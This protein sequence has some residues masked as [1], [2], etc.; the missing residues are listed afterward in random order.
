MFGGI[1]R[2]AVPVIAGNLL[3]ELY[4][5]VDTLIVGRTLG[6][7]KLAA[8][9][10]TASLT[11]LVIGFIIGLTSGCA[12]A[13]AQR[14]GAGDAAGLRRSVAAHFAIAAVT[15]AL[16]TA[17]FLLGAGP[18]LSLLQTTPETY[19][20]ARTYL[21][22][23]YAGVPATMLYN[24]LSSLLRAIGNSKAPL[25]FLIFSS[26]LN[27]GLDFLCILGF[28]WDVAGAA[29]AAVASQLISGLLCIAYVK[30]SAPELLPDRDSWR[31]LRATIA[32]ELKIGL[33]LGVQHS[34]I[35]LG[36]MTLQYF[37]NG[38]GTDA[39]AA[40][41]IG[42]KVQN[43]AQNPIVSMNTVMAT[44]VGQ[45]A[46]AR[47]PER[48]RE[49][50]RKAIAFSV[51]LAVAISLTVWLLARP[52]TLLFVGAE[53]AN[54]IALVRQYLAWCC[55]FLWVMGFLFVC[56]GTLQGLGDGVTPLASSVLEL[57]MRVMLSALLS[58]SL[59][60]A[61][62]CIAGTAAWASCGVLIAAVYFARSRRL[63]S[64]YA[65]VA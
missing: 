54:V 1:L 51:C 11:F 20:Y 36:S 41:T 53:E 12:V 42:G 62:V 9:G 49:G 33:P 16:L 19:A 59:G 21:V 44:Y 56:R 65:P 22:I 40:Y 24:L 18:L 28:G 27:I 43:L 46:G 29:I 45:N 58:A 48:I 57:V 14:F 31:A 30:R 37:L 10:S 2:F 25:G 23:I 64:Q 26:A 17:G 4:S 5:V 39:V 6:V 61:A 50:V 8:V 3:Q 7:T 13:S 52:I 32:E 38:F 60:Y 35:A 63:L 15:T 34:F 55:P 47:K